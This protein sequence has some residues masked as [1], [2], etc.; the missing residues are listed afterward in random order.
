MKRTIFSY[1]YIVWMAIFIIVPMV[2][3]MYYAFSD[4]AGALS[5]QSM[6]EAFDATNLTVLMR[7]I[8][9]AL[10]CTAICLLM[11]Y[12]VGAVLARSKLKSGVL[13]MLIMLPMWMNFLLRT[14]AWKVILDDTGIINAL[15]GALGVLKALNIDHV[16]F[17]YNESAVVVG[18]VYNYLPFMILPIYN[19][20]MK[21]PG[22]LIEAAED[23]GCN[24]RQVFRKVT[25]PLSVPGIISGI[26]MVFMPAVSTFVISSLMGGGKADMYGD[27]IERKFM[28]PDWNLGSA[29]SLIMMVFIFVSMAIAN[30][31][32]AS[33]EGSLLV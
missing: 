27:L 32:D 18:M 24:S 31:T 7:S 30:R 23:L 25:L 16:Q 3:V 20:I 29:L 11:G 33:K 14:Y 26:T 21:I 22:S 2:L 4:K 19:V 8:K 15:L 5:T 13:I 28:M 12:P 10:V 17:L 1:P 6:L 9:L